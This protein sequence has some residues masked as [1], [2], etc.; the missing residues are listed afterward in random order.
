MGSFA[1]R[2]LG[3]T[4]L[5]VSPLGIGGGNGISSPDLLYAFDR[6]VNYIFFSSDLHHFS[7][8]QS[9]DAIRTLCKQGSAVREKVVLATVSYL[10]DPEKLPAILSD[11]FGELGIEYIDV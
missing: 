6:G 1:M 3:K 9:V 8:R 4:D 10:N 7:Y 5:Q 11:Q 2:Q